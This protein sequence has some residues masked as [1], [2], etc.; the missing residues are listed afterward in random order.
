MASWAEIQKSYAFPGVD[1]REDDFLYG[2]SDQLDALEDI[3]SIDE[4][5]GLIRMATEFENR[6]WNMKDDRVDDDHDESGA[7]DRLIV[8]DEM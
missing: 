6:G 1:D 7:E 3:E 8:T 5:G 2:E 4:E